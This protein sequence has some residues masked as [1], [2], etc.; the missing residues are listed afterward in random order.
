MLAERERTGDAEKTERNFRF[1]DN[2]QKYL[3]FVNTCGEKKIVARRVS[4]ELSKLNPRPPAIRIFDAG[5]G[6]GTVLTRV[7]R[8][9]HGRFPTMPFYVVGKEISLEDVRLTIDKF[10]D[11]FADHPA[12]VFVLTN[13]YYAEAPWLSARSSKAAA[14]TIWHEVALRGQTSADFEEEINNLHGFLAEH[15]RAATNPVSGNPVYERPVVLVLYRADHR[16]MLNRV[17]PQPGAS[18][19][20]FDLIVASQPYR[21]RTSAEFKAKKVVTPLVRALGPGGRLIGIHS[22]G[23][24]PGMDIIHKVWPTDDPFLSTRQQICEAVAQELGPDAANYDFTTGSDDESIFRYNL[25]TLPDE[26]TGAIGTSTT[27]AAWNA[28]IYV[29][30]VEDARVAQTAADG[31]YIEATNQVLQAHGGLWFNDETYVISRHRE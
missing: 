30:Q 27:F 23:N 21:A 9:M 20:D 11:R 26:V 3:L 13:M 31:S 2:R 6:D 28:A 29:A 24:D 14:T 10:P 7:L 25:E 4:Q 18:Q 8:S 19:A 16:F 1:F 15:W 17:I 22:C 12:T 5:V